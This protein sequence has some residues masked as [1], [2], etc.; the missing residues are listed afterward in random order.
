MDTFQTILIFVLLFGSLV[1]FHE[2]G[3]FLLAKRSGILVREFAIGFGPKL[4]ALKKGETMYTIRILPLGG[5]VRMAGEDPEPVE[6]RP[7]LRIGLLLDDRQRAEKIILDHRELYPEAFTVEIERADLEK[8]LFIEGYVEGNEED[9]PSV[10][11]VSPS[12]CYVENGTETQIAPI[13]RQFSSKPLLARTFTILAGPVFNLLLAALIFLGLATFQGVPVDE[14]VLGELTGDGVALKAGLKEGDIVHSISGEEVSS[15]MNIVNIIRENPGKELI[16]HIERDGKL[17]D[18][19][20]TPKE[21]EGVGLIGVHQPV[22]HSLILSLRYSIEQTYFYTKL[23]FMILGDLISGGFSI[24]DLSGPVGIYASTEVA[25]QE[26]TAYL[27]QW[28]ALL[29]INLGIMNLLP[30]PALDGGRLL[31]FAIEAVR[32]KPVDKNKEGL[33]HLIGFALLMLLMLVVT[34]NDIQRFFL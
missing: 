15:W 29:S 25:A 32:G 10:F 19:P 11:R 9:T 8:E 7:G 23:I 18:I 33:V 12:A 2:F 31:F 34:W 16:F 13:D 21:A 30:I 26:G 20:V 17:L 27:L 14:P 5:Y 4:F 28:A 24:N 22:E 6:L 3:H 1:F